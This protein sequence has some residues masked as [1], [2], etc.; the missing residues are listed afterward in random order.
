MSQTEV[1]LIKA[2]AVVTADIADQAVSLDKLPHGTSSNNGKFLRANNGADPTFE[3]IDLTALSASNLTSGT[4]PDARF[5]ATLPAVS[6]ANLTGIN[7]DLVSDTSPQLGGDLDTNSF[8]INLDDSHAVNF[9]DSQDAEIKH[10]GSN[11]VIRNTEGNIRIEPKNGELG[12]QIT[13]DAGTALYYDNSKKLD[14][15]SNGFNTQGS[16]QVEVIIGSTNAGGAVLYLDGDS[17]GDAS[18]GANY[19]YILHN[20]AGALLIR[21]RVDQAIHLGTNDTERWYVYN[22]GHFVPAADN[23]YDIGTSSVRV[24]NIYTGDL[25][26][27]NKGSS[28]DVDGTWGDYTIQEGHEDL[29]LINNRTGKKFKFNL[30][31]VG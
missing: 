17:D 27:S 15:T 21:N 12:I 11:F 10:T 18:G 30:T 22:T 2:A 7:T 5:P 28:N 19:A 3:T 20:T 29:F 13:P 1:Q 23:T 24:R 14:T 16:G 8:E 31:E 4:I 9:G 26:L 25:H 6:G